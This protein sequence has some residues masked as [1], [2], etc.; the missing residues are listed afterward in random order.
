MAGLEDEA[1][2]VEAAVLDHHTVVREAR[3]DSVAAAVAALTVG[4]SV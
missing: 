4:Q 2:V 3:V 1:A